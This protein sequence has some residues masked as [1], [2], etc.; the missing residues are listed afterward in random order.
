MSSSKRKQRTNAAPT[1][2]VNTGLT[3]NTFQP[4][5]FNQ[6]RVF[7]AFSTGSHVVM[8]GYA[9]TGKTFQAMYLALRSIQSRDYKQLIIIRS[10][11]SGRDIGFL[12]GNEQQK[13]AVYEAPYESIAAELY[14]RGDAYS[15]LKQRRVVE[16]HTTSFLRGNTINDSIIL[17]DESQNMSFAELNTILTRVGNNCRVVLCGDYRQTD[18]IKDKEKQGFIAVLERLKKMDQVE[19]V[20]FVIEDIVRSGFCRDWILSEFSE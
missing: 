10:I 13:A 1:D 18:L 19:F 15:I 7:K 20:E 12:P 6:A 8:H 14:G 9:G 16:F 4:M 5:T 2:P 17:V 3:L 11:V